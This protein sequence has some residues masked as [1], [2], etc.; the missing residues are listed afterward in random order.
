MEQLLAFN[1]ADPSHKIAEETP[2]ARVRQI[3]ESHE[4]M[5][6]RDRS[7][8]IPV[9]SIA[10]RAYVYALTCGIATMMSNL[11]GRGKEPFWQRAS[12][13]LVKVMILLNQ[14]LDDY[15]TLFRVYDSVS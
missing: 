10:Q 4:A 14:T 5:T 2:A 13:N 7:V 15:V 12:T 1:A 8:A 9:Q 3:L 11:F 6:D